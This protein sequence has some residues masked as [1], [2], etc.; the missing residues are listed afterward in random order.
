M[1]EEESVLLD[2]FESHCL[3]NI[4]GHRISYEKMLDKAGLEKLSIRRQ[5]CFD[6]FAQKASESHRFRKWFPRHISR[7]RSSRVVQE[8]KELYARTDRLYFSPLYVMRRRLNGK[9]S[10]PIRSRVRWI[11]NS[12]FASPSPY[13]LYAFALEKTVTLTFC[14]RCPNPDLCH[15]TFNCYHF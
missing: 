15:A 14:S 3:K 5:S 12:L 9:T 2:R 6:K 10:Q 4:Y 13:S 11:K 1:T 8:F 7:R